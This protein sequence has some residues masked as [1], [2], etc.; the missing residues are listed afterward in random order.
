MAAGSVLFH[1][2]PPADP[3]Q[4]RHLLQLILRPI[5]LIFSHILLFLIF[6]NTFAFKAG[7]I[8]LLVKKFAATLLV[9]VLYLSLT[10]AFHNIWNVSM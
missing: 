3:I 1:P 10:V 5:C 4:R 7:L 2:G 8:S 9:G 6:F